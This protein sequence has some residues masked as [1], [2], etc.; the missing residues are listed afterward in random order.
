M[1]KRTHKT[2]LVYGSFN[3]PSTDHNF[4]IIRVPEGRIPWAKKITPAIDRIV[5][6]LFTKAEHAENR[7]LRSWGREGIIHWNV[8]G[9]DEKNSYWDLKSRPLRYDWTGT[10]LVPAPYQ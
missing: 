1:A 6:G 2:I 7:R 3:V 9:D 4:F 5:R 8:E 10:E